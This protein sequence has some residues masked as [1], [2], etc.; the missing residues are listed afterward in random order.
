MADVMLSLR[1]A[2][3]IVMATLS[4]QRKAQPAMRTR[5]CELCDKHWS[6]W[7]RTMAVTIKNAAL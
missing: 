4:E 2:S 1:F 7:V 6:P 3:R 5:R